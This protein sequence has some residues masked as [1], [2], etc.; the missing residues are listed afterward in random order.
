MSDIS[1]DEKRLVDDGILGT[2]ECTTA[3]C[4]SFRKDCSR[5]AFLRTDLSRCSKHQDLD[6]Q[7]VVVQSQE[8]ENQ[9]RGQ[10]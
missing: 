8:P 5:G 9:I 6:S 7:V 4:L 10:V 1:V 3:S 2:E